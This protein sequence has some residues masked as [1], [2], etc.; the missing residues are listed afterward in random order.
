MITQTICSTILFQPRLSEYGLKEARKLNRLI[1]GA[2]KKIL[3]LPTWTSS[4]LIQHHHGA[5][6][7]DLLVTTMTS[8][9]GASQKIKLPRDVVS[10]HIGDLLDPTNGERMRKLKINS[11]TSAKENI[12]QQRESRIKDQ[13]NGHFT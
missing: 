9:K 11:T 13:N 8:P 12:K 4:N 6:I 5:N 2:V 10:Q 1:R 3:H 7:P